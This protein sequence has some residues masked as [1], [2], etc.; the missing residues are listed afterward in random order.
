MNYRHRFTI[1]TA[2]Y[3]RATTL[4]RLYEE[5]KAQTFKDFEW[6]IVNDGSS[7]NTDE[8][9]SGFVKD[10]ILDI[11]YVSKPNGGKHTAWRTATPMFEGRYVLTADDDDP[12]TPDMLEVFNRHWLELER[13]PDYDQFW[14]VRTRCRRPDGSLVGR[15]LPTPF[16]D[17]D[18]N[19]ISYRTG[20]N[21]EMVGC[22]KV[23]VLRKEAAVPETFPYMRYASNFAEGIRWSRAARRYKTRF[24]PEVTRVYNEST[25]GLCDGILSRCLAGEKRI[26]Y[27]KLCEFY[28]TLAELSDLLLRYNKKAYLKNILGYAFLLALEKPEEKRPTLHL[29]ERIFVALAKPA[30]HIAVLLK[31]RQKTL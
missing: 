12:V 18:Y 19:T 20:A 10:G 5:L 14:E 30:A 1:F 2:T 23:E 22:R 27:N 11:R 9:V 25:G 29:R 24:V 21:C 28:F 31:K 7:D 17:S 4:P 26:I 3:N 8:I 13:R 16:Y 6:I 15:P